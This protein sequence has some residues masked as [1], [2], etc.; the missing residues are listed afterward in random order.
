MKTP[1]VWQVLWPWLFYEVILA[2]L[3]LLLA[4]VIGDMGVML[5]AM[6]VASAVLYPVYFFREGCL[7][8]TKSAAAD[9]VETEKKTAGSK[10]RRLFLW[11]TVTAVSA[12]LFFNAFLIITGLGDRYGSYA[13]TAK[14]LFSASRWMQLLVM[15]L[16]APLCE[17]VIFR[18]LVYR[19]IQ[20]EKGTAAAV[21]WSAL[22][23][24]LFHGNLLQGIYADVLGILLALACQCS[25]GAAV[26]FHSCAN[27]SSI[28]MNYLLAVC[29]SLWFSRAVCFLFLAVG[30]AGMILGMF[31]MGEFIVK[32]I[33]KGKTSNM[34][35]VRNDAKE[36]SD[37]DLCGKRK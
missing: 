34:I 28:G 15:G 1:F 17:E 14:I 36:T 37:A 30:G 24:A 20:K 29:P 5:L 35:I 19:R 33:P 6:T 25:F 10:K 26:W 11:V 13:E 3:S 18:G 7:P 22:L 2:A 4:K 23:F 12:C 32:K 16:A 8:V 21:F 27:L 9:T 31:R